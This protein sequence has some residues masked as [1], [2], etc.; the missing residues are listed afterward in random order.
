MSSSNPPLDANLIEQARKQVNRL[1]EEV[2]RLSET[3]LPAANYFGEVLERV[4]SAIAAPAG[5]VWA[6]TPQGNLQLQFQINIRQVGLDKDEESKQVHNELLRQALQ[7]GRP[8]LLPPH[9]S[10]GGAQDSQVAPG[11]PTDYVLLL[12]PIV[13]EKQVA[14][15][16]EVWQDPHRNPDA[17]RG[18]LQFMMRMAELASIYMRNQQLRQMIGQQQVWTQLEAFA[19]TVHGSLNPT[20]VGYV[21]ANEGRRMLECDRVSVGV[22][23]AKKVVIEA[24]SGADVVEKRSKL[25]QLMRAL[26]EKVIKWGEKLIYQGTKDDTLPPDVLHALD[27]YLAESNSKLLVVLPLKDER[28]AESKRPPRAAVVMECFDPPNSA[29]QMLARL[30]V[31]A[32]HATPALYNSVEHK[33]IPMRFIWQPLARVQDGLGGKARAIGFLIAAALVLL[34][35]A[36]I[37]VPYPLKMEAKGQLL[38]VDRRMIYSPVEGRVIRF[39]E[40][41][42][43][44][45]LVSYDHALVQMEDLQ[46]QL[47]QVKLEGEIQGLARAIDDRYKD[48]TEAPNQAQKNAIGADLEAK[49]VARDQ[50]IAELKA[51]RD[52][53]GADAGAPG[54]FWIKAP[55]AGTILS[56]DFQENLTNRYV[57]PSEPLLRIGDKD[58]PWEIEAKIP[59]K[60]IGQILSAYPPNDPNAELEVDYLLMTAPERTFKGKLARNKIGSEA[61]P[62]RDDNNESEPVVWASIRVAGPDIPRDQQI[63][64]DQLVTGAE[65]HLKVRCGN[66]RM[67]Y[68]LFYGLW[69]FYYEKVVFFF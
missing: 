54:S 7:N 66:R 68:S 13:V 61:T 49:K 69:E 37:F 25:V 51:L 18:F 27:A 56:W 19:R 12:A 62:N 14:G 32:R 34:T 9:S 55:I 50:K 41:I 31:V 57:K 38:P 1:L 22:R 60:H 21:V 11:N 65:V 20:E 45:A 17:Q 44:G 59:Q 6:R 40:G 42:K 30:E 58:G 64:R 43:P 48:L 8:A 46:L 33:R 3:D 47:Q 39:Q 53:V 52:R 16:I 24:I 28:E 23:H 4:L 36:L 67:G 5:A 35:V 2:A 29:E 10:A 63:S 26:C 15:F